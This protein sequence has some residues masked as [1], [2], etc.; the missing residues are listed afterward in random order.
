MSK[1]SSL[2]VVPLLALVA[3][4]GVARAAIL[5]PDAA[6]CAA[7]S[8]KPAVLVRVEGF[9][10]RAGDLRVQIYGDDPK[11]FL[12]K[13][14]KL[15]R[16]DLPVTSSGSMDVCVAL[17]RA[18]NYAVAVRH[19]ADGDGKS[20][21]NDG[22]GFSRNPGLSLLSLKPR[23]E[24]VVISVGNAPRTVNIVLNYVQGLSIKP[25]KTATR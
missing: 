9:K 21:R 1:L 14:H 10:E 2:V 4:V 17:P 18:G 15:R 24:D 13:G 5:G 6:A 16:I 19:D 8:G 3:P 20:G 22:G 23:Y 25:V 7:G 12:A 11:E